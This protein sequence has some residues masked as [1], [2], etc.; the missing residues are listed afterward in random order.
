MPKLP[1]ISNINFPFGLSPKS[2]LRM[3]F[4]VFFSL[5]LILT[6]STLTWYF[7][8]HRRRAIT[9]DLTER[10]MIL[11]TNLAH[12][13][14][15]RYAGLVAED[16]ETLNEFIEGLMAVNDVVYV[17]IT[18][19]DGTIL[20]Q[21]SKGQRG[22]FG[23][24]DR[25]ADRPLYPA[26]HI[27]ET[28]LRDPSSGPHMTP[29]SIV[30][31][32]SSRFAWEEHV[33]DFAM[34][35]F[36]DVQDQ[37]PLPTFSLEYEQTNGSTSIARPANASAVVQIGLTDAHLKQGMLS[38]VGNMLFITVFIIA[39]G[40]VGALV[41]VQRVTTPL[42]N[43]TGV[44][45]ELA[46]GGSPKPLPLTTSDEVGQLTH[47]FNRMTL[48]LQERTTAIALNMETI[49]R[50]IS[51]L[52][53]V[54][55]TSA[56]IT[57]TLDLHELLGK[58]LKLLMSNLG[59][60][61]MVLMLRHEEEEI[62]Y[63]AQ[64]AGV[65]EEIA[66]AAQH[67]TIPI[68]DNNTLI[69]DLF[70]H[71]KPV[72]VA[73]IA[74]VQ[75]RMHPAILALTRRV[76]VTSFALVPLQS[77]NRILGFIGGDRGEQ[78]STE[79]DLNILLTIASHVSTA[80]DNARAYAS[81]EQLSQQ[82]EHHIQE[83]THELSLANKRLQEHDQ[84]RSLFFS[85]AS[86][87]LRTPM[88]AI[89]SFADNMLDGVA[90]PLT[91]RQKAYLN[92]IGHNL[93]RLTRIINQLLDWSR[94]DL[95]KETLRL[96]QLSVGQIIDLVA[97]SLRV[98]ANDKHIDITTTFTDDLLDVRGDRDKMEQIF[99]N[100]IGNAVK[101]TPEGGHVTITASTDGDSRVSVRIQD[102]GCGIDQ[103]HLDKVFNEFSK[104]PSTMPSSQGAQLGLFITKTL[105]EM[106]LGSIDVE[107]RLGEGTTFIVTFPCALGQSTTEKS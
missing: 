95:K 103:E 44:A 84:R 49:S 106:H 87:E 97:D 92:R 89:R 90:G 62:A 101:F 69:S 19:A 16:K 61:R 96:E 81:L 107:S 48:S 43:L 7:I 15:F 23:K 25:S 11:L 80:I 21:Q 26:S 46:E 55:Q 64:V 73:D 74:N 18:K 17:V 78:P 65:A 66:M 105:V 4:V 41:L 98:V 14:H 63:V 34:S 1:A 79:E 76:G 58:I 88:T 6:C 47:A 20:S 85:V 71:A 22:S 67:L 27:A 37:L 52:T 100:L 12:N 35:I 83:R 30:T 29:V 40:I 45:R 50:Q 51:Q 104:V 60:S 82:Q 3:K 70:I 75:N 53:T 57:S 31:K 91:D 72:L 54:Y 33:Y 102:T 9:E 2:S 94:L 32:S 39:A 13:H 56:A 10:G 77:H 38:T 5:I 68:E 86:H 36:R 99:W 8:D 59:F 42:Q 93:T 28:L 24:P